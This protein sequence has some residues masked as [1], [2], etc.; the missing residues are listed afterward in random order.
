MPGE[1][2][3]WAR[4]HA[5]AWREDESNRD[6]RFARNR[7]RHDWIPGLCE[8][9]NPQL[10]RTLGNLAEAERRDREWIDGLVRE[11][12]KERIEIGPAGIQLAIDGWHETPDAL[13]RRLVRFALVEAGLGRDITRAHLTRVL[14]FLRRGRAAGREKRI[15]L[16]GGVILRRLDNAF[17]LST[18]PA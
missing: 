7:L 17:L 1:I 18:D 16:P 12:V 6:R 9:F 5:I 11:A 13:A 4:R 2:E 15:E 10:L 8:T 14:E 3:Q